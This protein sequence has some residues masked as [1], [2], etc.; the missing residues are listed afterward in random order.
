LCEER[1]CANPSPLVCKANER[2]L[3]LTRP[4]RWNRLNAVVVKQY[5]VP[6]APVTMLGGAM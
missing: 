2:E 3:P 4:H 1:D 6:D 5:A